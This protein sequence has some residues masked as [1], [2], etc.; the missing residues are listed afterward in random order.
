MG[1]LSIPSSM[2]SMDESGN[3]VI[4]HFGTTVTRLH[5]NT[6]AVLLDASMRG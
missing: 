3:S 4:V 6:Y 5:S 1:V 2:F